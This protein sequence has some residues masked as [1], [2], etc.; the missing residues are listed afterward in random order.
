[1]T[2][3][4]SSRGQEIHHGH[5][6]VSGGWLRPAVFGVMDGLV[7]NVSLISG[8]AG[9]NAAH[10]GVLLAGVAG[11]VSGSL[12]MATGEYTSVRSQ[13]EAMRREIDV[14]RRELD[15]SPRAELA[16][17]AGV[18][19]RRGVEEALADEVARQLS[20][21]PEVALE[22][23]TREEL[24]VDPAGLP[25]PVLAA[26]S[27]FASFA[28]GAFVP[29]LPYLAGAHT[30]WISAALAAIALFVVGV[31]VSRFTL[32][33]PAYSGLRQLALGALAAAATY[34]VGALVGTT[35]A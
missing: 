5:R 13:N 11:L 16:E 27:S 3:D 28:G 15:R 29:L 30:F 14:E 35:V 32:R 26:G 18:Y 10:N 25:S 21:D 33:S 23:H 1:V 7:S 20:R 4:Q 17:L 6:D 31:I 22:V 2:R 12:S 8:F 19:R 34:G 24:G 9:G